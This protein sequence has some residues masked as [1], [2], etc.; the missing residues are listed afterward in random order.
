MNGDSIIYSPPDDGLRYQFYNK[1]DDSYANTVFFR[2]ESNTSKHV[3]LVTNGSG[4]SNVSSSQVVQNNFWN[5]DDYPYG[6][7]K[8]MIFTEDTRENTDTFY[9]NVTTK[10]L[11]PVPPHLNYIKKDSTNYF[12]IGWEGSVSPSV[13]GYRLYYSQNGLN[14]SLRDNESVL[15]AGLN[16][17]QYSYSNP[18]PL[19]LK[20]H[21]VDTVS[22][23]NEGISSDVYGIR[24]IN[25]G[26]KVLVVDGFDNTNGG[27][28]KLSHDFIVSYAKS[29]NTSF[30]S[31]SNEQIINGDIILTDY[32]IVIWISGDESK[33]DE[34]FSLSEQEKIKSFLENGGKLFV[35]GS[36]IAYDLEG[37]DS[38]SVL[39]LDFLRFYLKARYIADN[40]SQYSVAAD[41]SIPQ[42][43][44]LNISFGKKENGSFY[45]VN[46]PD[47]IETFDG[48][49]PIFRYADNSIA[50]IAFTGNFN[51]AAAIGKLVYL[52]FPFETIN[53]EVERKSL[54]DAVFNYF[55]GAVS[56]KEEK[57][58]WS[59]SL[60]QNYPNP[61]NPSTKIKYTIAQSGYVK[62]KVYDILGNE[63]EVLVNEIQ[64][65]GEYEVEFNMDNKFSSGVYFFQLLA[66][67]KIIDIKK[68]LL[69]K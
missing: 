3:Y 4:A 34:T 48:S 8:V 16:S 1:P 42:F 62:L 55:S 10:L 67:N 28:K 23:V 13:K 66:G 27:W 33:E 14:Y 31:C 61:F 36:D 69:L 52:A 30:E 12:S 11:G 20:L 65:P 45:N 57:N 35:T 19:F 51:N 18:A 15:T 7:Y 64:S 17:F 47:V 5:A 32:S 41:Q 68:M 63:I 24:M 43:S 29:F 54:M 25:D 50:G 21:S 39:N 2:S 56:V 53:T 37:S 60:E 40:S 59:Y 26:M 6:N 38:S 58:L 49:F 46:T 44:N 22:L 9:V